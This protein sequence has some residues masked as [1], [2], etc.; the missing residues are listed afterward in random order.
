MKYRTLLFLL[1]SSGIVHGQCSTA[2]ANNASSFWGSTL[3]GSVSW[4]SMNGA[5]ASDNSYASSSISLGILGSTSTNYLA[6][7]GFNFSIPADATI[8]GIMVEIEKR[9]SIVVG[10]LS[11]ISDN[12][13]RIIKANSISG[14]NHALPGSWPSS[15]AYSVYGGVADS[16]GLSWTPADI[17]ASGFG[18]AVSASVS[19]GLAALSL[20]AL[21]DHI[22]LTVYYNVPVPVKFKD[23]NAAVQGKKI[24]LQW[25]TVTEI[26]SSHFI[27]ERLGPGNSWEKID[28]VK[29]AFNSD[30]ELHYTSFDHA[31]A[32]V[33]VYRI[34]EVD[35]DGKCI[36]SKTVKLDYHVIT[37]EAILVYPNPVRG[38]LY[39]KSAEPVLA[40]QL[41]TISGNKRTDINSSLSAGTTRF[42]TG[43][44]PPGI[45]FLVL[46]TESRRYVKK[47][48]IMQ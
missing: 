38:T 3:V 17:N 46:Q 32:A 10:L 11:S 41:T 23:F 31:P 19:A 40:A 27:A 39:I 7:T 1:V 42:S 37:G 16:W 18:V 5:Q 33:N 25:S 8:C 2:G 13:V 47:I 4:S 15:D 28:S 12:S 45:Y 9:Y 44:L 48:L 34:K 20:N 36:Y 26:N 6:A 14:T 22:R 30:E 24:K 43:S 21:V 29:A 35:V